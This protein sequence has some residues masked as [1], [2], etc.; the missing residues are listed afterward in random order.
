MIED[1][2]RTPVETIYGVRRVEEQL[3]RIEE[4]AKNASVKVD[5]LAPRVRAVELTHIWLPYALF[6]LNTAGEL[7]LW[8]LLRTLLQHR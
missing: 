8:S 6:L 5:G 3:T 1:A 7:Y 2:E 4:Y